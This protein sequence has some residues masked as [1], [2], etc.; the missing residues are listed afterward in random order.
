MGIDV[1]TLALAK[2]YADGVVGGGVVGPEGKPGKNG[3]T[4]TP[5]ISPEGVLSWTNDGNLPNPPNMLIK[6]K[7]GINGTD[8]KTPDVTFE[9]GT[10][11]NT[12][13]G[14]EPSVEIVETGTIDN[15]TFTLNFKLKMGA[16]GKD[17]ENGATFTPSVN[18]NGEL[19]W[20]NDK[21]L[22]NPNPINIKGEKGDPF[23]FDDFTP[24]QLEGLKGPAGQGIAKG[25]IT[26]QI[27]VKNSDTDYDTM[28]TNAPEIDGVLKADGSVPMTGSLDLNGNKI[29]NVGEP[30]EAT[31]GVN[32]DYV[33]KEIEKKVTS[34]YKPVGSI[35]FAKLPTPTVD[36]LG[37]VYNVTDEFTADDKFVTE[38]RGKKYSAG[39]NVAV[40]EQESKYYYDAL[41]GIIDAS[42]F[43]S[44]TEG[45]TV[46]NDVTVTGHLVGDT[47]QAK[48]G[49]FATKVTSL[50]DQPIPFVNIAG[51]ANVAIE[52]GEPTEDKH[53]ATKAYVDEKTPPVNGTTGQ[54]L[55]KT[56]NGMEWIDKPTEVVYLT[57]EI[58]GGDTEAGPVGNLN[59]TNA[60]I[61]E[62]INSGKQVFAILKRKA[63]GEVFN[64]TPATIDDTSALFLYTLVSNVPNKLVTTLSLLVEGDK[65]EVEIVSEK[66]STIATGGT[67]GQILAKKSDADYD[68]EWVDNASGTGGGATYT[69]GDG[70]K[71]ENNVISV[72]LS[73]AS[74]NA[75]GV[76]DK[77]LY[78]PAQT[79]INVRP[80][81]MIKTN[82][83]AP[84][85]N[86]TITKG[87]T[88]ISK[89]TDDKGELQFE[90]PILGIW[91]FSVNFTDKNSDMTLAISTPK[92]YEITIYKNKVF[93][94][95]WNKTSTTRLVRTDGATNFVDPV[96]ALENGAGSSPF[97]DIMPWKGMVRV[98]DEV[99]GTLVAIPKY[100][101]QIINEPGKFGIK[102]SP[103]KLPGFM[104]SPAHMDR[105]DGQ[106]ERDV[107]YIGRYLCNSSYKSQTDTSKRLDIPRNSARTS[108][109]NIG[110]EYWQFDYA[111]WWTINMLYLVEYADWNC[112]KVIG[113]GCASNSKTGYTDAM[114]YHTGTNK[115]TRT[116]YGFTQYRNIEGLWDNP[117][118]WVDGVVR[119]NHGL[120]ITLDPN[121]FSDNKNNMTLVGTTPSTSGYIS[122]LEQ[123][124]T[125]GFEWVLYPN[126]TKGGDKTYIPD[127]MASASSSDSCTCTGGW[128]H[129]QATGLFHYYVTS[130][131]YST[132]NYGCRLIKL[133]KTV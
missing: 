76:V 96:A 122:S 108:I 2:K 93:G 27:L 85:A 59:M 62:A 119:D 106:G 110:G 8:G 38:E 118:N 63:T 89:Q 23:T 37:N 131:G 132:S 31:D 52:I 100:Y 68:T 7:D 127:Y 70:I 125:A 130:S 78:T 88:V 65:G 69:A 49:L 35:E 101:F 33:D 1:I 58:N 6:G 32:K 67:T 128:D 81:V 5:T 82:P 80:V 114:Q 109:H 16:D 79:V 117:M 9:I 46:N 90:V 91:N 66:I 53:A 113:Y 74:D 12:I 57:G 17:G 112:Q 3:I 13:E 120:Y 28:W 34:V 104:V 44:K 84:K 18:I 75:T 102:I 14:E 121:L 42:D 11:T 54:I 61:Y 47:V 105:G 41:T 45:G 22:P 4:F 43:L 103:E 83:V 77:Q 20:T 115:A 116:E 99:A 10:V 36:I 123:S 71:I 124:K 95:E 107:V 98:E 129:E 15:P 126:M 97:D 50:L 64:F 111:T 51:D 40:I 48:N 73:K 60:Q 92:I 94:V 39:T 19:S 26:G 21:N 24:E 133:P 30:I 86:V 72:N 29:V 56:D 25:G 87:E 55:S